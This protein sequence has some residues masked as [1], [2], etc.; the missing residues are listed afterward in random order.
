MAWGRVGSKAQYHPTVG[1]PTTQA[2]VRLYC[3]LSQHTQSLQP[4]T[5]WQR[6]CS[7]PGYRGL[8]TKC[9]LIDKIVGQL[10]TRIIDRY[11]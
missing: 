8:F 5:R 7:F 10:V 6:S 3:T 4:G 1:Y 9:W 11:S 2:A